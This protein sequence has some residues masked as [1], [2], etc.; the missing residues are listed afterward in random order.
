MPGV[1]VIGDLNVELRCQLASTMFAELRNDSLFYEQIVV[2]VGGTAANFAMAARDHFSEVHLIGKVGADSF[3]ELIQE[4]LA[5]E[6]VTLYCRADKTTQ[7]GIAIHLRDARPDVDRG[8]RLLLVQQPS[9]NQRLTTEDID[10]CAQVLH[11]SELVILDGYCLLEEPRRS[12]SLRA[13]ELAHWAD[14]PVV[15][16]ILPHTAYRL[17]SLDALIA[18]LAHVQVVITELQTIRRFLGLEVLTETL[19]VG[20]AHETLPLLR[21]V[22]PTHIFYLRFGVGHCDESLLCIPSR[23]P[24][25]SF[26]GY[27]EAEQPRGFGDRLAARELRALLDRM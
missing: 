11:S 9:A 12:A 23:P 5:A 6:G 3:G 24:E 10:A 15:F 4:Q 13:M 7:T 27:R 17:Y 20:L 19:D 1:T 26:T 8:I 16:D 2:E 14:V 25:H 18:I 22:F 21:T